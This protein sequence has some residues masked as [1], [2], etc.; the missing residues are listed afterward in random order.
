MRDNEGTLNGYV[1]DGY[2]V[3][4]ETDGFRI[5]NVMTQGSTVLHYRDWH[6]VTEVGGGCGILPAC[7]AKMVM[8]TH[9]TAKALRDRED[10]EAWQA[11]TLAERRI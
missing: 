10:A 4:D 5:T 8:V 6:I 7:V 9:P 11:E 3:E 1:Y 2:M